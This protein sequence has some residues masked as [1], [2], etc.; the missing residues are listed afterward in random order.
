MTAPPRTGARAGFTL[1]EVLVSM[2]MLGVFAGA[3]YG[4]FFAGTESSRGH[5]HQARALAD[6]RTATA[7]LTR[8]L[9]QAVGQEEGVSSPVVSVSPTEV[10]LYVDLDG[11]ASATDARPSLV[12]YAIEGAQLV[13][14]EAPPIGTTSPYTYGSP[15]AWGESEVLVD[16]VANGSAPLFTPLGKDGAELQPTINADAQLREVAAIA[17]RLVV[18]HRLGQADSFSEVRT[19]VTLRNAPPNASQRHLA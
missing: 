15:P 17:L 3:L 14:E 19:D 6:A 12:R 2:A 4:F 16:D 13:R 7:L 5:E 9:R 1:V 10:L 8:D 18:G 11:A